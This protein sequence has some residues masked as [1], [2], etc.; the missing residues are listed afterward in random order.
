MD[1]ITFYFC[2]GTSIIAKII[3]F[4][5]RSY[6]NHVAVEVGGRVYEAD[7]D[8]VVTLSKDA[9]FMGRDKDKVK[10]VSITMPPWFV[11]QFQRAIQ[12]RV[13]KGYDYAAL[14]GYILNTKKLNNSDK[15]FCSELI[16]QCFRK[17]GHELVP[18][19]MEW[20]VRPTDILIAVYQ[21]RNGGVCVE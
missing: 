17:A 19:W 15:D 12:E 4:F 5:T 20:R 11:T 6:W 18:H 8:G 3:R 1:T 16:A 21:F 7:W 14:L 13:G 2:H 9:W 10:C